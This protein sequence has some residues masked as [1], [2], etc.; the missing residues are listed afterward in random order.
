MNASTW[1]VQGASLLGIALLGCSSDCDPDDDLRRFAGDAAV[2]CGTADEA[3]GR[4]DVDTCATAEF[5]AHGAFIARYRRQGTDSKL[6]TAV[7]MNS[8]GQVKIFRWDS[9]PCGGGSSCSPVTDVQA[10]EGPG[11]EL[12]SSEDPGALPISCSSLG[13]AQRVCE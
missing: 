12:A 8:T 3:Q 7:A 5:L 4:A 10:C 6:L 2:D 9:S 11:V 1:A 13:L